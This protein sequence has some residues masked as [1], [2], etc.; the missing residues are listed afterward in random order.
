MKKDFPEQASV[1]GKGVGCVTVM[2]PTLCFRIVFLLT[3]PGKKSPHRVR[4]VRMKPGPIKVRRR[5]R[6][7]KLSSFGTK[8]FEFL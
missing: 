3:G 6:K 1:T 2:P 5:S 8:A 7:R 4:A